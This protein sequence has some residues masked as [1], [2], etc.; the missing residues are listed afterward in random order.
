MTPRAASIPLQIVPFVYRIPGNLRT[1]LL[2]AIGIAAGLTIPAL[3]RHSAPADVTVATLPASAPSA[4]PGPV[5]ADSIGPP[6]VAQALGA[7]VG[8]TDLSNRPGGGDTLV[9]LSPGERVQIGSV[10]R[11]PIGLWS[12]DVLWVKWAG[13]AGDV[14]GFAPSDSVAVTAGSP[15]RLDLGGV[16][17]DALLDP[18]PGVAVPFAAG[19]AAA[20]DVG[21][22]EADFA[23][24]TAAGPGGL[25]LASIGLAA[26]TAA[27]GLASV[28]PQAVD[29]ANATI[30]IPWIPPTVSQWSS[31]FIEAGARHNVDPEFIAIV[32]TVE[33]GGDRAAGS[34]AGAQGLMQ[35]MPTT[36]ELIAVERGILGFEPGQLLDPSVSVD[37]G[38]YYLSQQLSSFGRG[39]DPDWQLSVEMAASAYN[40]GPGAV[41][42][43]RLSAETLRYRRWVGGMWRERHLDSSPTYDQWL[44]AGGRVLI[45]AA[46]AR[47]ADNR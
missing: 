13:P 22:L 18:A 39:D 21:H 5:G 11:V 29:S 16:S 37:F 24:G 31:L 30:S 8:R 46:E 2:L 36:G 43:G 34:H 23:P 44:A 20:G 45:A 6:F 10:V 17:P 38:A 47:M 41:S 28:G 1:V 4:V 35:V 14:F 26:G 19:G 3:P 12:A 15:P 9:T 27:L 7:T 33:S 42:S 40:G 32:A 25:G